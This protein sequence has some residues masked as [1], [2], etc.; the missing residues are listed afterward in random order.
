M[1][2]AEKCVERNRPILRDVTIVSRNCAEHRHPGRV[3][4]GPVGLTRGTSVSLQL[5]HSAR[6]K[7][8]RKN[9]AAVTEAPHTGS[10]GGGSRRATRGWVSGDTWPR[11]AVSTRGARGRRFLFPLHPIRTLRPRQT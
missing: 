6:R 1:F 4:L 8:S 5:G 7:R 10:V 2:V 11:G 3:G 9:V